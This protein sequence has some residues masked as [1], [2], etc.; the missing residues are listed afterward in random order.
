M[1]PDVLAS[2]QLSAV[3]RVLLPVLY[4]FLF[5]CLLN[6]L[7]SFFFLYLLSKCFLTCLLLL[8]LLNR[9]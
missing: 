2:G 8:L 5:V 3:I 7:S 4:K 6:F 1:R 9:D